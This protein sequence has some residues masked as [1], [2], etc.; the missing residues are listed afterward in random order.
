MKFERKKKRALG[1]PSFRTSILVFIT[2][3]YSIFIM[4]MK[5]IF[6]FNNMRG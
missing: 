6:S 3:K 5:N 2:C 1:F 4:E